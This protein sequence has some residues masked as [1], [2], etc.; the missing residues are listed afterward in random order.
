M[1]G[2]P[3][4]VIHGQEEEATALPGPARARHSAPGM[5]QKYALVIPCTNLRAGRRKSFGDVERQTAESRR[6]ELTIFDRRHEARE[7]KVVW[8]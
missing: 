6:A 3:R 5:R 2:L 7:A 4:R 1:E 8:H